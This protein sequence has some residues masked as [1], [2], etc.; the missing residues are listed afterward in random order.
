VA[1]SFVF[2]N[3]DAL[4]EALASRILDHLRREPTL[5]LGLPT[6]RT[7]LALY[8]RLAA[9]SREADWSRAQTFNLDE[10]VGLGGQRPGSYRAFM[11]A[12]LFS[13]LGIPTGRIGFLDGRASD[14]DEECR[15]YERAIAAA[16][17]IDLLVLGIGSNG[18]IGFN[19]P[20]EALM[21]RTHRAAL[22]PETRAANAWLFDGDPSRV[23]GAA[24][25]M[26]MA[27]ILQAR[28]IALVATGPEKAGVVQRAFEGPVTTQLPASFLQLHTGVSTWLDED[29]DVSRRQGS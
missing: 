23:P 15:R 9:R 29:A 22:E 18:H 16:G 3:E 6:G 26:G 4:A 14:L 10:F 13:H 2:S 7:P 1:A 25:T 19:E 28:A 24:L 20:G 21:A 5:V 8:R 11:D 27:T 12:A 17:G